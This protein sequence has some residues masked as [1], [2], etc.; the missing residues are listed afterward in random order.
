M[1]NTL[2]LQSQRARRGRKAATAPIFHVTVQAHPVERLRA[3]QQR[4]QCMVLWAARVKHRSSFVQ[5]VQTARLR[6]RIIT[7]YNM[8]CWRLWCFLVHTC[9]ATGSTANP[10]KAEQKWVAD[11]GVGVVHEDICTLTLRAFLGDVRS[12]AVQKPGLH[13][14][15]PQI[16][17]SIRCCNL[18]QQSNTWLH[19]FE[20]TNLT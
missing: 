17:Q 5:C 11:P 15:A 18:L 20:S 7:Y 9:S 10:G 2:W 8:L 3:D 13:A 6:D 14:S 16:F 1:G 4:T 19:V 12:W